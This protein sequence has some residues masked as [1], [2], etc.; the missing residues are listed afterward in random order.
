VQDDVIDNDEPKVEEGVAFD[1]DNPG[2]EEG[3]IQP[4][5]VEPQW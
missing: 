4:K 2:E 5:A 3:A 1:E